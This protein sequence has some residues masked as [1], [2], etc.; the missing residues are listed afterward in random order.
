MI[1]CIFLCVCDLVYVCVMKVYK[2]VS[3]VLCFVY[4]C[5]A[6]VLFGLCSFDVIIILCILFC[7]CVMWCIFVWWWCI[8]CGGGVV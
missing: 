2:C 6:S 5:V 1:W 3:V 4:I 8:F 7:G